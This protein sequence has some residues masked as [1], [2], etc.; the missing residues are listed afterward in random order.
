[1]P[2]R[3]ANPS[4]AALAIARLS[5]RD[6]AWLKEELWAHKSDPGVAKIINRAIE[7]KTQ[8]AHNA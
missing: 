1:M 4:P 7:R 2:A 6:L 8:G 5:A 3:T